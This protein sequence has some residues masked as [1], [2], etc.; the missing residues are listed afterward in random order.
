MNEWII[1]EQVTEQGD[2]TTTKK[3]VKK[4]GDMIIEQLVAA[5]ALCGTAVLEIKALIDK[6][7]IDD[8]WWKSFTDFSE[9]HETLANL[10]LTDLLRFHSEYV[11][12]FNGPLVRHARDQMAHAKALIRWSWTSLHREDCDQGAI[13]QAMVFLEWA[14]SAQEDADQKKKEKAEQKKENKDTR[15]T[16]RT[17]K[18]DRHK[19]SGNTVNYETAYELLLSKMNEDDNKTKAMIELLVSRKEPCSPDARCQQ[20]CLSSYI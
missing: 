17:G 8:M 10:S 12:R 3:I 14:K 7:W 20:I 15:R 2:K 9:D 4:L 11:L 6:R 1:T 13:R 18:K 5:N 19:T 16:T